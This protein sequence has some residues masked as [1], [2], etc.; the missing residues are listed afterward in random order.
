VCHCR[1]EISPALTLACISIQVDP[2]DVAFDHPTKPVGPFYAEMPKEFPSVRDTKTGKFRKVIASPR[3]VHIIGVD[4]ISALI[5]EGFT[6]ICAGGGGAL[7]VFF[8]FA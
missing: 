6:V 3:P 1:G 8:F 7:R 4:A 2:H 5:N